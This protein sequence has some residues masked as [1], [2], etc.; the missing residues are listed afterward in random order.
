MHLI[1]AIDD[2]RHW[3]MIYEH[4]AISLQEEGFQVTFRS[5]DGPGSAMEL[6]KAAQPNP[7]LPP[8]LV[9]ICD[10]QMPGCNGDGLVDILARYLPQSTYIITST[11]PE[12]E[13]YAKKRGYQFINKAT[14]RQTLPDILRQVISDANTT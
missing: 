14:A 3:R 13:Q 5:Y 1:V 4:I 7:Q 12:A 10:F 2:S 11:L 6:S 9:T 8:P